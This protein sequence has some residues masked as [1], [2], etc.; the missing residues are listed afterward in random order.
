[1]AVSVVV[2][3]SGVSSWRWRAV[4]TL[5]A[6]VFRWYVGGRLHM[7]E[8]TGVMELL[9]DAGQ[10]VT[11][12]VFDQEGDPATEVESGLS[13]GLVVYWGPV[14]G[15]RVYTVEVETEEGW[16]ERERVAGT[17]EAGRSEVTLRGLADEAVH[18]VRVRAW[19][20]SGAAVV[21]AV[22]SGFLVR[23][24]DVPRVVLTLDGEAGTVGFGE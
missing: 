10:Q 24:P 20:A 9:V 23:R 15:A 8:T 13:E 21:A 14:P 11:V 2:E 6:P 3:R 7:V 5:E 16:V 1:M 17:L 19:F 4:S 12:S 18:V 22:L